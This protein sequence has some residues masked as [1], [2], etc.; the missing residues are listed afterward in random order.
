MKYSNNL[1][2]I[3]PS[4]TC[5]TRQGQ[6]EFIQWFTTVV[7]PAIDNQQIETKKMR[8]KVWTHIPAINLS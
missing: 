1:E 5:F 8:L 6:R 4:N 2:V 7:Q 3:I